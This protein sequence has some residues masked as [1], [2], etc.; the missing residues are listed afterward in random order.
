MKIEFIPID[1][2]DDYENNSN[3]HPESQLHQIEALMTEFGWTMPALLIK[4][5]ER[6]GL[7]AGHGRREVA[8]R[9]Y[10][11]GKTLRMAEGTAI[12]VNT[13]PAV[14]ANGWSEAQKVAYVMADNQVARNSDQDLDVIAEEIK[15]LEEMDFDVEL[16]G[17]DGLVLDDDIN[18]LDNEVGSNEISYNEKLEVVIECNNEKDQ[19]AIYNEMEQRGYSCRILSI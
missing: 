18:E 16:L 1:L 12:P 14:F 10:D 11:D 3:K 13:I 15:R 5:G 17:F 19:E 2:I 7:I 6:Y 4:N 9:I 8:K